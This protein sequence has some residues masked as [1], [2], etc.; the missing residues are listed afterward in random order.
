MVNNSSKHSPI[1]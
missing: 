1:C